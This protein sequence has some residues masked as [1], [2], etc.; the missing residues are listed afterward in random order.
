MTRVPRARGHVRSGVCPPALSRATARAARTIA[1]LAVV[2]VALSPRVSGAQSTPGAST[3]V[4]HTLRADVG[5]VTQLALSSHWRPSLQELDGAAPTLVERAQQVWM[6]RA[7]VRSNVP[8]RVIL[9]PNTAAVDDTPRWL[10][11]NSSNELVAWGSE[12][13]I[14]ASS[15][16]RGVH[17][18]PVYWVALSGTTSA[19]SPT[20]RLLPPP[21]N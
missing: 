8:V 4:Q 5:V 3:T 9:E 21:G 13:I 19:P 11:L 14:L 16:P 18:I 6:A 7:E 12:P 2:G 17:E 10:V 20:L 1:L 15:L